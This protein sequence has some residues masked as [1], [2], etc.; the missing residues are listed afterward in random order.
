MSKPTFLEWS[1]FPKLQII[2]G[3]N[4]KTLD[5]MVHGILMRNIKPNYIFFHSFFSFLDMSFKIERRM[6]RNFQKWRS[7]QEK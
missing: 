5:Y 3:I 2:I 1:L 4:Y 6:T 7:F